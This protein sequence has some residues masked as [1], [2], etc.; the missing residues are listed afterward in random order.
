MDAPRGQK[1]GA[2]VDHAGDHAWRCSSVIGIV[3][4]HQHIDIGFDVGEHAPDHI[5]LALA[6]FAAHHRALGHDVE[7]RRVTS[8]KSVYALYLR[9]FEKG[10]IEDIRVIDCRFDGV[11]RPDVI[12][13]VTALV[14]KNVMVNGTVIKG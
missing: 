12:E 14:R 13:G 5:A 3:A 6:V 7:L 8:R 4:I 11:A 1:I 10:T 9:G 2:V